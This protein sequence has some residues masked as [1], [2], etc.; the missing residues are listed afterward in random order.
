MVRRRF[1]DG[2]LARLWLGVLLALL[3][4]EAAG[5][6]PPQAPPDGA[7]D[8]MIVVTGGELLAG[9]YADGHTHFLTRTLHPLGMRCVGSLCVDDEKANIQA[10]LRFAVER[11]KLVIVTGGL[12]PTE[13]DV[14]REA[15]SEFTGIELR[16]HPEALAAMAARFQVTPQEL[17]ANLRRQTQ[18]PQRGTY[19]KNSQGTAIGLVFDASRGPIVALPGPPRELQPMVRGELVPYLSRRFGTHK[20]GCSLTVRFVGLGQSQISQTIDDHLLLPAETIVSSQFE[21]G[22]VDYTFTLPDDAPQSQARLEQLKQDLLKHMGDHVYATDETS[23]EEHVARLLAGRNETL[24]LAEAGSGGGLAEGMSSFES[25]AGAL[26]APTEAKLERLLGMAEGPEG[27]AEQARDPLVW[28]AQ[29][30]AERTGS[31]W[32]IAVG[33]VRQAPEGGYVDVVLRH[34]DGRTDGR[35]IILRGSGET[36]RAALTTQ[37]L[38]QL[39]RTLK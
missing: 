21:G 31:A 15:L 37:L 26:V 13:N 20:P 9:V 1:V 11:A 8:Y 33:E 19:F 4:V 39:R 30:T 23:L 18:V 25:L 28:I 32:A 2:S 12:G 38:D 27:S 10:A 24:A 35:R 17:R 7:V 22:R 34:P 14:T 6:E 29:T 36:A 5:A 16:E 3:V